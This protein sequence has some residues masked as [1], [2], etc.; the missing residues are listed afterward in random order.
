MYVSPLIESLPLPQRLALAYAPRRLRGETLGLFALD[1]HLANL[2]RQARE[3]LLGQMRLAWWRERLGEPAEA[4]PA[5]DAVLELLGAWRGHEQ[6]LA[7]LVD[8][9]EN[10]LAE[11]LDDA[12]I[13]GFAAGRA[14]A[15]AGLAELTGLTECQAPAAVAGRRWA[16]ADLAA[17]LGQVEERARVRDAARVLGNRRI[18]LPRALRPLAVLDGLA[19]RSLAGGS[20]P[21]AEGPLSGLAALRLG[22][23]GR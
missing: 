15:F 23:A 7:A 14:K 1:A 13:E 22:I 19:R 16:L 12:A 18:A 4:R 9:W 8:G 6:A 5:G 11:Q 2:V 3:P 20:K 17:H 10:L 21:L